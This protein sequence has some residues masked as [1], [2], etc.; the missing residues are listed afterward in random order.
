VG[1]YTITGSAAGW[2]PKMAAITEAVSALRPTS[3]AKMLLSISVVNIERKRNEGNVSARRVQA[4]AIPCIFSAYG[5]T[6]LDLS[7]S[8][9]KG[10]PSESDQSLGYI[11][12]IGFTLNSVLANSAFLYN[13]M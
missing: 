1:C 3:G 7:P 12:K 4:N 11:C 9:I 6:R 10:W 8:E 5:H 13:V 2:L